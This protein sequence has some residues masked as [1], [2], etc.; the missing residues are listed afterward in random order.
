[1]KK[2][3][4]F[5]VVSCQGVPSA[6]QSMQSLCC[7]FFFL[8]RIIALLYGYYYYKKVFD[9]ESELGRWD[10]WLDLV[11]GPHFHGV[12]SMPTQAR[13]RRLPGDEERNFVAIKEERATK[14]ETSGE[15]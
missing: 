7:S 2:R 12:V 4:C 3:I 6:S 9:F 1:V 8:R 14:D 10:V 11:A 13:P 5:V 15:R